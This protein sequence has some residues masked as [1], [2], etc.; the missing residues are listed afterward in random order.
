MQGKIVKCPAW[1]CDNC[2]EPLMDSKQMDQC[3][4]DNKP[5]KRTFVERER[6]KIIKIN[7]KWATRDDN[8]DTNQ[9]HPWKRNYYKES[10]D[11]HVLKQ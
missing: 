10:I 3:L 2:S 9:K 8:K 6:E 5:K 7:E 11:D 4:K 1:I